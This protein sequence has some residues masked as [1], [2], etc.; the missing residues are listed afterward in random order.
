[1]L[2]EAAILIPVIGAILIGLTGRHPNL[3]EA[4]TLISSVSLFV[5]VARIYSAFSTGVVLEM[6]L[7]EVVPGLSLAFAIEPL[8][9]LF[10]MVSS[11]LWIITSIYS[12]GY[13]RGQ[14]EQNPD[15]VL[16]GELY[17]LRRRDITSLRFLRN[18]S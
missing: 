5:I 8:G 16:V 14:H 11:F 3:R 7:L 10:A 9:M 15:V 2:I 13:M 18:R 1:M 12:I 17:F 4:V 6:E